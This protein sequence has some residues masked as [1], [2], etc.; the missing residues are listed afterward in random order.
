M[1]GTRRLR[2]RLQHN[3]GQMAVKVNL[4]PLE[5]SMAGHQLFVAVPDEP[6]REPEKIAARIRASM[7][8]MQ[9]EAS[10]LSVRDVYKMV[11]RQM[12]EVEVSEN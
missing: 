3:L 7:A 12:Q 1:G 5:V 4:V 10:E 11:G 6:N 2:K 8:E 9:T